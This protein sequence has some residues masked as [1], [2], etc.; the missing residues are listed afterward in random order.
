[1]GQGTN[2]WLP[3]GKG[4]QR[5]AKQLKE[6]GDTGFCLSNEYVMGIKGTAQGM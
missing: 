5:R 4:V 3:K 6:E 2:S 1:M